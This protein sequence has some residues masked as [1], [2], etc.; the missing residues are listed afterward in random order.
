[1]TDRDAIGLFMTDNNVHLATQ[2]TDVIVQACEFKGPGQTA[3]GSIGWQVANDATIRGP[4]DGVVF[5]E[6][7]VSDWERGVSGDD[8]ML[9]AMI[10]RN[11]FRRCGAG[12]VVP[13]TTTQFVKD[14]VNDNRLDDV[15]T[16]FNSSSGPE[17]FWGTGNRAGFDEF[18]GANAWTT[19]TMYKIGDQVSQ[20]GLKYEALIAHTSGRFASDLAAVKWILID[21]WTNRIGSDG[22]QSVEHKLSLCRLKTG[23]TNVTSYAVNGV[24]R[25]CTTPYLKASLAPIRVGFRIKPS[26]VTSI[27]FSCGL[28]DDGTTF[29]ETVAVNSGALQSNAA[30]DAVAFHF[31]TGVSVANWQGLGVKGGVSGTKVDAGAAPRKGVYQLLEIAIDMGGN[32]TFYID[33]ARV[34]AMVN[35]VSPT[36]PLA[37]FVNGKAWDTRSLYIDYQAVFVRWG[38]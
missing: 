4:A 20:S 25:A 23:A 16:P 8:L 33:G 2:P 17:A 38:A 26:A 18:M 1:M 24:Q 34:G 3:S 28:T 19:A 14:R 6:N 35:A 30:T 10:E 15:P 31:Q 37:P 29:E 9:N 21:R 13:A 36:V 22:T 7:I 27:A 12:F 32:A 11:L 5:A